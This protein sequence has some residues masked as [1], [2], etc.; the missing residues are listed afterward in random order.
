MELYEVEYVKSSSD[1]DVM[2]RKR[3]LFPN[4][5]TAQKTHDYLLTRQDTFG[6]KLFKVSLTILEEV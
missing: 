2:F 5:E 6:V 3:E 4:I 1:S